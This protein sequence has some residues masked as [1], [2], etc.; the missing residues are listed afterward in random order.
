[1]G[2]RGTLWNWKPNGKPGLMKEGG[3]GSP[4]YVLLGGLEAGG[5]GPAIAPGCEEVTDDP[6]KGT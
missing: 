6:G 3:K 1:M 4:C 5:S 2:I